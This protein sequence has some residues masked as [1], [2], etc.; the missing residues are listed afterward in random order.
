[1][2]MWPDWYRPVPLNVAGR[3]IHAASMQT[4]VSSDE[5]RGESR[6]R[7]CVSPRWAVVAALNARGWSTPRIGA[8]LG[9]RDHTTIMHA[10]RV[11]GPRRRADPDFDRLCAS[12]RSAVQ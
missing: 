5:I 12:V 10:L 1:M 9:N 6:A 4:G 3:A 8:A 7:R 11:I 2:T